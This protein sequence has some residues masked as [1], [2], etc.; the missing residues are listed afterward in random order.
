MMVGLKN[1]QMR[2]TILNLMK[3]AQDAFFGESRLL[4]LDFPLGFSKAF[5]RNASWEDEYVNDRD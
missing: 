3:K 4:R 1:R 5:S 2:G